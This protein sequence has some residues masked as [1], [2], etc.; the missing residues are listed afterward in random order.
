MVSSDAGHS[1]RR[2]RRA[3]QKTGEC[4]Q[5]H[6]HAGNHQQVVDTG[7]LKFFAHVAQQH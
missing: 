1:G 4:Q 5:R 3:S 6:V 2:R 7:L